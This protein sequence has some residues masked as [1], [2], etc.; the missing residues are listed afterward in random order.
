[1]NQR[2]KVYIR[3]FE[4]DPANLARDPKVYYHSRSGRAVYG[5]ITDRIRE[6]RGIVCVTGAAGVG[7]SLLLQE[8]TAELATE[9]TFVNKLS[10]GQDFQG[11]ISGLCEDLRVETGNGDIF[12]ALRSIDTFL[13]KQKQANPRIALIIDDAHQLEAGVLDK[14]LLLSIPPSDDNASL[15]IILSGLPELEAKI[16]QCNLPRDE[17][18]K[19]FCHRLEGLE[20]SEVSAFIKLHLDS[21]S[22]GYGDLFT[23]AAIS[24]VADYS[25]GI[26]RLIK[27]ICASALSTIGA[28]D[29][30]GVTDE[31]V[32]RVAKNYL[33]VPAEATNE[34]A[35]SRPHESNSL[36]SKNVALTATEDTLSVAESDVC[37]NADEIA[38]RQPTA[39]YSLNQAINVVY[40]QCRGETAEKTNTDNG[41]RRSQPL[42]SKTSTQ[43]LAW[44]IAALIIFGG[45]LIAYQMNTSPSLTNPLISTLDAESSDQAA[46]LV[47]DSGRTDQRSP[48]LDKHLPEISKGGSA[49]EQLSI[50]T[51]AASTEK[52]GSAARAFIA[53]LEKNGRPINL[54]RIYDQAESLRNQNQPVDVYLLDFYAAKRG[55]AN[56]AFRLAQM[57]D[58]AT[59]PK[60]ST[61]LEKP[62]VIQ[63][64]KW[65]LRA[66][67]AGHPKAE[68]N[69]KL[70]RARVITKADAGDGE[71][72]RLLMQFKKIR[73]L[74]TG[75]KG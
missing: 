64:N 3:N 28:Q 60:G 19:V 54:D 4:Q 10:Q 21:E 52:P 32:D 75:I 6:G 63:A 8:I 16:D 48:T 15:Q 55:H 51:L 69:L 50:K 14:V 2:R 39:R 53:K 62:S 30:P 25:N 29:S 61:V 41:E 65:Y 73:E 43:R 9:V 36:E 67:K 12:A 27:I 18:F 26:P 31:I 5:Q 33:L 40:E 42:V 22:D 35:A 46:L 66:M 7:K 20:P 13:E 72:Q 58:P 56:A 1:M 47:G 24:R 17:H 34:G 11:L 71:A 57:A 49:V 37:K 23:S 59:F 70:L 68:H 45:A 38:N 74:R 44:G